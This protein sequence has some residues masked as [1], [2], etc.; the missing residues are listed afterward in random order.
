[1]GWAPSPVTRVDP[2]AYLV[3]TAGPKRQSDMLLPADFVAAS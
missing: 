3:A 2:M 1:M